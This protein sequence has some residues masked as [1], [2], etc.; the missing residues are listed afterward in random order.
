ML[1][2]KTIALAAAAWCAVSA[3]AKFV[4]PTPPTPRAAVTINAPFDRTWDAVIDAFAEA[5]IPIATMER[6][7]GFIVARQQAIPLRTP[8]ERNSALDLADCGMLVSATQAADEA[9][10]PVSAEYNVVV[11]G[12]S[13]G[14]ST[15]RVTAAFRGATVSTSGVPGSGSVDCTSNGKLEARIEAFVAARAAKP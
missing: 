11:R 8:A 2:L 1:R 15:L 10:Y 12:D 5:V 13:A 4:P 7:S 6:A 9:L 3:C 14:R